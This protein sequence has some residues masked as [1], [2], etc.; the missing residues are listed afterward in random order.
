MNWRSFYSAVKIKPTASRNLAEYAFLCAC[1][2]VW[3]AFN[4]YHVLQWGFLHGM[5]TQV[6]YQSFCKSLQLDYRDAP[7]VAVPVVVVVVRILSRFLFWGGSSIILWDYSSKLERYAD[8]YR[9]VA[10][11]WF[12]TL[13]LDATTIMLATGRYHLYFV[14]SFP[15]VGETLTTLALLSVIVF[16]LFPRRKRTL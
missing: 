12:A 4:L 5:M 11:L 6:D 3:N 1:G 16:F 15:T 14:N 7:L 10:F 2:A 13:G 9:L 8:G